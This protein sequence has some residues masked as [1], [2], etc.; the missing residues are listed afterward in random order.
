MHVDKMPPLLQR[1]ALALVRQILDQ[2][3]CILD[4]LA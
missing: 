3:G 4:I 1:T 2:F